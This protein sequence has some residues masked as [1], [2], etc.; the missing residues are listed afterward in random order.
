MKSVYIR[1]AHTVT[2]GDARKYGR[3]KEYGEWTQI[4]NRCLNPS[5]PGYKNYGGRGISICDKWKNSYALFLED[6]GRAPTGMHSIDR[7]DNDG[8]YEPGNVRWATKK[9]QILNRRNVNWVK[10]N[11]LTATL[12]H[13]CGN[14]GLSYNS[15]Y[16]LAWNS[17]IS[18]E[19]A[20]HKSRIKNGI[21]Y[22]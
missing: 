11:G 9:E 18:L 8:N 20:L 5:N 12:V 7:I 22:Y 10:M 21:T 17:R 13:H 2:H 6:V 15:V 4:K 1:G 3:S 19:S 16:N 14:V